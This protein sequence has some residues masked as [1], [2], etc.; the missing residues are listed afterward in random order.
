MIIAANEKMGKTTL[1]CGAPD[2]LLIPLEVGFGGV[3]IDKTPMIQDYATFSQLT[4]EILDSAKNGSFKYRTIIFDSGTALERHI[5]NYV[6]TLD[7]AWAEGN[8]RGVTMESALGGYGKAYTHAN[9]LFDRFLK[10]CDAL[11]INGGINIIITCHVFAAKVIDP[12]TGEFD[13]WDLLLHS[14]KNQKTYGKRE[15][16]TQ[17][18]DVIGFLHE[19]IY[20]TET[21]NVTKAVSA[22]QGRV[23][24]L[25]RTP[26]Y[27]AGNRYNIAGE[28]TIPKE[29]GWN[30]FA[31]ALYEASGIDLYNRS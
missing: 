26:S 3:T 9:E 4:E 22:N 5:H 23:L 8:P 7:P 16:I 18:A 11:A 29:N 14:P 20:L 31:Q 2:A 17:W 27:V 10:L 19:P 24:G 15:M 13:S 6:L 30:Y 21:G 12:N 25:D 1:A 28:I